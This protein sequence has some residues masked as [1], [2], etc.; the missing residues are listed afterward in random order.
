M[1][2]TSTATFTPTPTATAT[3][4]PTPT[5]EPGKFIADPASIETIYSEGWKWSTTKTNARSGIHF[6]SEFDT[7]G[8][9]SYS[10]HTIALGFLWKE[11]QDEMAIINSF[12]TDVLSNFVSPDSADKIIQFAKE[13]VN[14]APGSYPEKIDAFTILVK[15]T[16]SSSSDSHNLIL[17]ISEK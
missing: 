7:F 12:F 10:S 8:I 14:N 9:L 13:T 2:S 15:V 16:K 11:D 5:M 4:T 3:F 1:T 17:A 6:L